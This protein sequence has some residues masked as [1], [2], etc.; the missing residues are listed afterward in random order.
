MEDE[1]AHHQGSFSAILYQNVS[2][3]WCDHDDI[4]RHLV[5]LLAYCKVFRQNIFSFTGV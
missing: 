1:Y 2:A 4:V 5:H 3:Q